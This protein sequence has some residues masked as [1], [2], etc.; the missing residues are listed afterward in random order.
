MSLEEA[1]FRSIYKIQVEIIKENM[2]NSS[3]AKDNIYHHLC[4]TELTVA[5][6]L[7]ELKL[8]I[9]KCRKIGLRNLKTDSFYKHH[10]LKIEHDLFLLQLY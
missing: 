9:D 5:S 3:K 7:V 4:T 10:V 1:A 6:F 2:N 8:C